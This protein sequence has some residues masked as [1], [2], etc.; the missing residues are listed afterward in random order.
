M[1]P[2]FHFGLAHNVLLLLAF[3]LNGLAAYLLA[4]E[5]TGSSSA[6]FVGGLAFAFAP[7]HS[8]HLSHVQTVMAFGMPLALLRRSCD[9]SAR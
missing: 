1:G 5:V 3:P 9:R 7:Y 2:F 8:T 6:A 4:R